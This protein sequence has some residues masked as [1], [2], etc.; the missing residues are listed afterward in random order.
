MSKFFAGGDSSSE[1]S[2]S[3]SDSEVEVVPN[4]I[5]AAKGRAAIIDSDSD[6]DEEQRVVRSHK[7]KANESIQEGILK[8]RNAMKTNDW[9]VIHDEYVAVNGLVDKTKSKYGVPL[10]YIKMLGDVNELVNVTLKDKEGM[11]KLRK[12]IAHALNQTK[13]S[14][15]KLCSNIYSAEIND[16]KENPD[17]YKE[18]V[19]STK[20]SAKKD[21]DSDSDS[22]SESD[23]GSDS[24]S[25]SEDSSDD[26]G[27]GSSEVTHLV[28][29]QISAS[30]IYTR[31]CFECCL[32]LLLICYELIDR[33][34]MILYSSYR[35]FSEK[36]LW[37]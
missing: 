4:K 25:E 10:N 6:S 18:E 17:K 3:G 2:D 13:M 28:F 23:D 16:Y 11:K 12:P 8:I 37:K 14:I 20:P 34:A 1:D 24:D 7:D 35:P 26:S 33:I 27:S 21:S 9:S 31:V 32:I 30:H 5:V 36:R 19:T 15:R 29:P 22:D